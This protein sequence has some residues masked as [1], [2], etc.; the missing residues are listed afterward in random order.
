MVLL[1]YYCIDLAY[2]GI[3]PYM[4]IVSFILVSV[5]L[6]RESTVIDIIFQFGIQ[7]R[8][9]HKRSEPLIFIGV[10]AI[11]FHRRSEPLI[12][13]GIQSHY[14]LEAFRAIIFQSWRSEP[15]FSE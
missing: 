14:F 5:D 4:E 12:C 2:W 7:S 3:F 10:R 13:I 8:Y 6:V 9:F 11:N 15:L 1:C